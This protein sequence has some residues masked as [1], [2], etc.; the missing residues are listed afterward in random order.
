MLAF[1][2]HLYARRA[3]SLVNANPV[4]L[5]LRLFF[6][7]NGYKI[8]RESSQ[9]IDTMI[10]RTFHFS[11]ECEGVV[12]FVIHQNCWSEASNVQI[13]YIHALDENVMKTLEFVI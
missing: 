3:V 2:P 4:K 8:V 13:G 11:P 1:S 12:V 7:G 9:D 10:M 6:Y 5:R